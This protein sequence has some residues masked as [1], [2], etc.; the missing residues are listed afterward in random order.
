MPWIGDVIDGPRGGGTDEWYILEFCQLFQLSV[1][2]TH[3]NNVFD[4]LVQGTYVP[5]GSLMT[6]RCDY[7][8][9][10]FNVS[11]TPSSAKVNQSFELHAR[12]NDH[13]PIQMEAT[14]QA[15]ARNP[16]KK[17]RVTPYSRSALQRDAQLPADQPSER[18]I[19]TEQK[20][21]A[22]ANAPVC[23]DASSHH[24][25]A[26]EAVKDVLASEYP[27]EERLQRADWMSDSTF[28]LCKQRSSFWSRF[29]RVGRM[30]SN[31]TCWFVIRWWHFCTRSGKHGYRPFWNHTR[32]PSS[33]KLCLEH[34]HGRTKLNTISLDVTAAITHDYAMRLASRSDEL[35]DATINNDAR[36]VCCTFR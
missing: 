6:L 30:L 14:L 22:I 8:L 32:G 29:N 4:P 3:T 17:R 36:G 11:V 13:I 33:K 31:A 15:R 18:K 2:S 1:V 7:F 20:L 24:F 16:I 27:P 28:L 23:L 10:S 5:N 21:L 12:G 19:R 34:V 35:V 26:T 25:V 9:V